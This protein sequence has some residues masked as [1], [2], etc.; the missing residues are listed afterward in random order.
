MSR[1]DRP[2]NARENQPS[3]ADTT[4]NAADAATDAVTDAAMKAAPHTP[5]LPANLPGETPIR[6]EA[7]ANASKGV[8][9]DLADLPFSPLCADPE[10]FRLMV[11]QTRAPLV[12]GTGK[13]KQLDTDA[14]LLAATVAVASHA[15]PTIEL[16]DVEADLDEL[17]ESVRESMPLSGE[18]DRQPSPQALLAHLHQTIFDDYGFRGNGTDYY[19]PRNSFLP[20]V[21]KTR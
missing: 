8:H 11:E 2:E 21:L 5:K 19:N 4:A 14:G 3:S 1:S 7:D 17:A 20:S 16:A 13:A 6:P 15:M 18:A 9:G 12:P 10:A